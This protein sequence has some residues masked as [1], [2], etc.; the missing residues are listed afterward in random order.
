MSSRW[1]CQSTTIVT[2]I[3]M[4]GSTTLRNE[5]SKF[6]VF[7]WTLNIHKYQMNKYIFICVYNLQL[8]KIVPERD[9]RSDLT[10][11]W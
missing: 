7:R 1:V 9:N 2:T 6:L 4:T 10:S 5:Y 8:K 11:P 3:I